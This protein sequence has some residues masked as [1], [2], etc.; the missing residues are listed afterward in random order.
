MSSNRITVS[1]RPVTTALLT[2]IAAW[3]MT[4][5]QPETTD[6]SGDNSTEETSDND[7][8][9][10][11]DSD[12]DDTG[13]ESDPAEEESISELTLSAESIDFGTVASGL[14]ADQTV[15]VTNTGTETVSGFTGGAP[16]SARFTLTQSCDPLL[17]GS[18]CTLTYRYEP[19]MNGLT[20][21]T[22][23]LT[24]SAGDQVIALTGAS[25]GSPLWVTSPHLDFGPIGVDAM[26]DV[27]SVTLTNQGNTTI[28]SFA[29]GAPSG[30][31]SATQNCAGGIAP[32]GSCTFNYRFTPTTDGPTSGE[33][34]VFTSVGSFTVQ[35][36][37]EGRGADTWV[38]PTVIDFGPVEVGD[39]SP[40][41]SVTI[42]NVGLADLDNF[43]GGAPSGPFSATQTCAGGVVPEGSCQYNFTFSPTEEG[44]A[45]STSNSS[46]NAGPIV[47]E[48]RGE[49][50]AV[51]S[52]PTAGPSVS[53]SP[54]A[55]D[56]GPVG[57]GDSSPTQ[58][59]TI[60]NT[61]DATLDDFAGGAPGG[62]FTATQN[63]ASGVAPGDSC[64][65]FISFQPTSAGEATATSNS[66]TNAGAFS[67]ELSGTG[68]GS[69]LWYSPRVLNFGTQSP[70]TTSATQSVTITNS[71]M[72]TLDNF[73]GGAPFTDAFSATQ[74]CAS[75]VLPGASCQY[76]LTY[77]PD[78]PGFHE[79]T[80]NSSTN[81]GAIT[82][83]L[84]GGSVGP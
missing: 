61:G 10:S 38:T 65:Y 60:T 83:E 73:A 55:L 77:S 5:C 81:A 70:G 74:S 14:Y 11:S 6:D 2:L 51:G 12:S 44:S 33:S 71:G 7:G 40:T 48:L 69:E 39:T 3:I 63:C 67:I 26:S 49:G 22:S 72:S 68:V 18:S 25:V 30:D 41:R 35:L 34:N 1:C 29:G 16:D 21:A 43:A 42:T 45:L 57:V 28:D 62:D 54:K 23:T 76:N 24:T 9:S 8:S 4:G 80:S 15:L 82:I 66:S 36:T 53:V 64:Q 17:P 27:Q 58:T 52:L 78:A 75:G 47:I 79:D 59:V 31:F 46:T 32:G 13:D 20:E 56:F 19:T 37:G 50:V 84:G